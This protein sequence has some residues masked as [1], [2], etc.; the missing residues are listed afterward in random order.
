MARNKKNVDRSPAHTTAEA[1]VPP[2][3]GGPE[4]QGFDFGCGFRSALVG[5][6]TFNTALGKANILG[7]SYSVGTSQLV[8]GPVLYVSLGGT[9]KEAMKEAFDHFHKWCEGSDGDA[10]A[11]TWVFMSG[12]GYLLGITQEQRRLR[13]RILGYRRHTSLQVV[14]TMFWVKP[15]DSISAQTRTFKQNAAYLGSFFFLDGVVLPQGGGLKDI[16][17]VPG[18]RPILITAAT[19][20]NEEDVKPNSPAWAV[21][22]T[23]RRTAATEPPDRSPM[24]GDALFK[25]RSRILVTHFPVMLERLRADPALI[26]HLDGLRKEYAPWQI[27]QAICNLLLSRHFLKDQSHYP[28]LKGSE[29]GEAVGEMLLAWNEVAD[30][31]RSRLAQLIPAVV[32]RQ[33]ALDSR[34]L[35]EF[36]GATSVEGL[37]PAEVQSALKGR[38]LVEPLKSVLP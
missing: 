38:G 37:G 6:S 8:P 17:S 9:D 35:L 27:E 2:Q 19:V 26:D 10:V 20:V 21:L 18:L 33:I 4:A 31:D 32:E 34:S 12:G 25:D 1:A 15:I 29:M 7:V 11:I 36:C 16:A 5:D 3:S 24:D 14:L 30:G 28:K 13:N 23:H 22:E